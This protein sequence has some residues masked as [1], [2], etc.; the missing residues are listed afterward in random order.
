MTQNPAADRMRL[1]HPDLGKALD[2]LGE[3]DL[4]DPKGDQWEKVPHAV[5]A[6][7]SAG[8]AW[9]KERRALV[10]IRDNPCCDPMGNAQE[11]HDALSET[12]PEEEPMYF[13][14]QG[15]GLCRAKGM[16]SGNVYGEF[17]REELCEGPF[18][19]A[20]MATK[21]YYLSFANED[22][23]L[24][25]AMVEASSHVEAVKVTHRLGINPG[26]DI[27]V[28]PVPDCELTDKLLAKKNRLL[29]IEEISGC[30][31]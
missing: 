10:E 11:A 26:G 5:A 1:L 13:D 21:T 4:E 18:E 17:S 6:I 28:A 25:G 19:P 20:D 7:L 31:G 9:E 23:F 3:I 14:W 30:E 24:G 8:L 29:T 12:C 2:L 22:G 16:N 27:L 15:S